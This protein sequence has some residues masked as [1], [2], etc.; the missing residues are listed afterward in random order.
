MTA[1]AEPPE[2]RYV[3]VGDADVAYQIV[4]DGPID[5]VFHHGMCHVDLQWD[6]EPEAAFLRALASFSRLILFDRR[7]T[8]ASERVIREA[9]PSWEEWSEDL[10]AVLDAAGSRQAAIFA[11]VDAGG[12]ALLFAASHP[13]RVAALIL[14]N[15]TAR[16]L[17][18]DDYPIGVSPD[19]LPILTETWKTHWGKPEIVLLS[20][21]SFRG[22][23]ECVRSVCKLLRATATPSAAIRQYQNLLQSD[24]RHI[25]ALI[26]VPTLVLH[27]GHPIPPIEHSRYLADHIPNAQFVEV[28]GDDYLYYAGDF[29]PVIEEVAEFLTGKR[30]A[31]AIDRVLA[32]VLFT[33]IVDSTGRAAALGDHRWHAVL[34]SHDRAVRDQL[35]RFDGRE[36]KHTGDGFLASFD[37]PARAIRCA[38][39]I[40]EAV[41]GL[42]LDL[43]AGLHTGE[44]EV[45]GDDLSGLAVHIAAR[46]GASAAAGEVVVSGTVKDL[47]VGSG[48]AFDDRG[49]TALKGVPGTWKLFA[50]R[51]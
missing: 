17:A 25:L 10:L 13:E 28:P 23:D 5:L 15:T 33:D 38:R 47:V 29:H 18:A 42:G 37:G 3:S 34:D 27:S 49:E 9:M 41:H 32:T 44:C 51:G 21:P 4:G 19:L 48:I 36:I 14:G 26:S 45:R 40:V 39:T 8:G 31:P 24:L 11:E 6:I 50:V 20:F 12:T 46:V 30:P 35:R 1:G 43:R 16:F 22:N 2:T 7:G